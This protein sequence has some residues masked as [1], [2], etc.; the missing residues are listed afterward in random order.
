M[1]GVVLETI[2]VST[3]V[4]VSKTVERCTLGRVGDS[5]GV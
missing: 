1:T 2:E 4:E 3:T 5:V